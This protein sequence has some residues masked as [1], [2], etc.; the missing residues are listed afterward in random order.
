MCA[1]AIG[2]ARLRRPDVGS[3]CFGVVLPRRAAA[4]KR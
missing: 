1:A 2:F 4:L 3:K